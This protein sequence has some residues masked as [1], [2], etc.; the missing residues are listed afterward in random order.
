[1]VI[2]AVTT[3]IFGF[4]GCVQAQTVSETGITS[5]KIGSIIPSLKSFFEIYIRNDRE[6]IVKNRDKRN[7]MLT[8]QTN[9]TSTT[10]TST[11]L[12][13]STDTIHL[14][15][16]SWTSLT[17][18]ESWMVAT[19]TAA[20][21][22]GADVSEIQPLLEYT[23]NELDLASSSINIL[24]SS[25]TATEEMSATMGAATSSLDVAKTNLTQALELLKTIVNN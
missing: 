20:K 7:I 8:A 10:S 25:S 24:I 2:V 5:K 21:D 11:L 9:S 14:L 18:I 17:N 15:T 22:S 1:M 13:A 12:S 23:Q 19:T 3:S 16:V 4:D 6:N